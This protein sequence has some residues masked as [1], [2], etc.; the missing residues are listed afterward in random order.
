MICGIVKVLLCRVFLPFIF[1][2]FPKQ[3]FL[4]RREQERVCIPYLIR[5]TTAGKIWWRS[6][7]VNFLHA[8][9]KTAV[10]FACMLYLFCVLYVI[11]LW[12][13]PQLVTGHRWCIGIARPQDED[14][15]DLLCLNLSW[16]AWWLVFLDSRGAGEGGP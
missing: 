10:L 5:R 11:Y 2:F 7:I 8:R 12:I 9:L 3:L 14:F 4:K 1:I 6:W 13:L 16:C 15:P